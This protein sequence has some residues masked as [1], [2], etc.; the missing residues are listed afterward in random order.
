MVSSAS[1]TGAKKAISD[2]N[3]TEFRSVNGMQL[4]NPRLIGF[5]I[6][7]KETFDA[8]CHEAS[9]AIIGSKFISLLRS[10]PTIEEAAK[11]LIE[12]IS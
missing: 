8:A 10:E 9:G 7:N 1:V 2:A 12:A 3:L 4:K 6:S 11:K 5:G